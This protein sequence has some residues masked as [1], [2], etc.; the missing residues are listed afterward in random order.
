M[1][2]REL[3]I[4]AALAP[5]RAAEAVPSLTLITLAARAG[6]SDDEYRFYAGA[7]RDALIAWVEA[8]WLMLALPTVGRDE[9]TL[10]CADRPSLMRR[11]A[12]A[13]P[14]VTAELVTADVRAVRP[15]RFGASIERVRYH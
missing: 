8:G 13:L 10:L 11:R 9:M 3:I 14:Y 6:V 1:P 12:L 4:A 15:L 5:G 2:W 7:E